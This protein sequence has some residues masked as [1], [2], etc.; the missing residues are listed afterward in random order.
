MAVTMATAA[1]KAIVASCL[2]ELASGAFGKISQKTGLSGSEI[3][4][5]VQLIR[6]LNPRPGSDFYSAPDTQFIF[7]DYY[8]RVSG[9][10]PEILRNE[11]RAI[12][13]QISP[14]YEALYKEKRQSDPEAARFLGKSRSDAKLLIYQLGQR[15]AT[16]LRCAEGIVRSQRGWFLKSDLLRPLSLKTL[17]EEL[18]VSQSTV[19]RAIS[20]RYI[21]FENRVYPIS[22]FLAKSSRGQFRE[23]ISVYHV[24]EL[25]S[26]IIRS[27]EPGHPVS[28]TRIS[29]L[30]AAGGIKLSR[31]SVAKYRNA[32]RLPPAAER[33]KRT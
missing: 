9:G 29:E 6:T 30:L 10:E 23:D 16:A 11:E 4:R 2:E 20:G 25:I 19:S 8:V 18:S 13:L 21:E 28:D 14:E 27:E 5:A 33:R 17:S 7:P 24:Q 3:E 22:F 32:L 31:H 26:E 15:D 1:A 12:E